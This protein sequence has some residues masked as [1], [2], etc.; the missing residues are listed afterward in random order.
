[1]TIIYYKTPGDHFVVRPLV[2]PIRGRHPEYEYWGRCN[3][4]AHVEG[5]INVANLI[6]NSLL[7]V[8]RDDQGLW[9]F[10]ARNDSIPGWGWR[11]GYYCCGT[12]SSRISAALL[13]IYRWIDA[14]L[15]LWE[16]INLVGRL[17]LYCSVIILPAL[18]FSSLTKQWTITLSRCCC[19]GTRF[20]SLVERNW[21]SLEI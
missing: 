20:Q 2:H 1:M 11:L 21:H 3:T 14:A 19:Y 16:P 10:Y 12:V 9:I 15:R 5:V 18:L 17:I 13:G 6:A 8:P 4:H 7:H